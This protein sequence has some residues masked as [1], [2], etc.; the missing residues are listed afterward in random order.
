MGRPHRQP[1]TT[2]TIPR[3]R[4]QPRRM[5]QSTPKQHPTDQ[6]RESGLEKPA[7]RHPSTRSIPRSGLK[8]KNYRERLN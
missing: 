3:T 8:T 5:K 1:T 7:R 2:P 6:G 4:R